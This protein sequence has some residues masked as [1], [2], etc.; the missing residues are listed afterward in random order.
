MQLHMKVQTFNDLIDEFRE[1]ERVCQLKRAVLQRV[2]SILFAHRVRI[3]TREGSLDF[4]CSKTAADAIAKALKLSDY[5]LAYQGTSTSLRYGCTVSGVEINLDVHTQRPILFSDCQFRTYAR[6]G[7]RFMKVFWCG[8][9]I[10]GERYV[11]RGPGSLERA[12]RNVFRTLARR[13]KSNCVFEELP[14]E[15]D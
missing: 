9:E 10:G 15:P 8:K 2:R 12:R 13:G 14:P 7:G 11:A 6:T 4:Y 3:S 1:Q 5:K